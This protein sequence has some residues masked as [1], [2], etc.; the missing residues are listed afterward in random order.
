[1][2]GLVDQHDAPKLY[3]TFDTLRFPL[4]VLVVYIHNSGS[5]EAFSNGVVAVHADF[6][7]KKFA[8]N[9]ISEG[10]A[11]IAVPLFFFMSGYLLFF[12]TEWSVATYYRKMTSRIGTLLIPFLFWTVTWLAFKALLQ[13]IPAT[14]PYFNS[15]RGSII[16]YSTF[17]ILNEIF[18]FT[19]PP[20]A[21]QFWFIRDLMVIGFLS[22]LVH[23][24]LNKVGTA[25]LVVL[26]LC[27]FA[28]VWPIYVP[29]AEPLLFFSI[30][31]LMGMRRI[32]PSWRTDRVFV[33]AVGGLAL[34][35]FAASALL[36]P[37]FPTNPFQK[38]GILSGLAWMLCAARAQLSNKVWVN[39]SVSL[40]AAAFFVFA[41]HEPALTILRKLVFRFFALGQVLSLVTY[42]LLPVIIVVITTVSYFLLVRIAP[43]FTQVITG[44]RA[45][46][47]K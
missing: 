26:G 10:V 36:Y 22:P 13:N 35:C 17:Q 21:Y 8:E 46:R 32:D 2:T 37:D 41:T 27:W 44:G 19:Q 33:L 11:R 28:N 4:I 18:G 38:V 34:I 45:A 30:G 47:A 7:I 12:N 1:M 42:F 43:R 15:A 23:L 3:K 24:F 14:A 16:H 40:S 29:A 20:N 31:G 5:T 9:F 25:V 6:A 39:W